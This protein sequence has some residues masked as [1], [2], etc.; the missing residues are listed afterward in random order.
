MN[1]SKSRERFGVVEMSW[2]GCGR[3]VEKRVKGEGGVYDG[4]VNY[5]GGR[6]SVE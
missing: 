4:E 6:G 3:G 1:S 5:G 2:G